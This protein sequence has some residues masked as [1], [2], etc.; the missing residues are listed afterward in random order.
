M[1][2]VLYPSGLAL[3]VLVPPLPGVELPIEVLAPPLAAVL[4]F[5][6][7]EPRSWVVGSLMVGVPIGAALRYLPA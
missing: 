3:V 1:G 5:V 2:L 6:K 4:L 7:L